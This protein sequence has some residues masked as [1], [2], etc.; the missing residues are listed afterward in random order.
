MTKKCG[1]KLCTERMEKLEEK[2]GYNRDQNQLVYVGDKIQH[3]EKIVEYTSLSTDQYII[4]EVTALSQAAQNAS[5][6]K[7]NDG[8]YIWVETTKA[9]HSFVSLHDNNEHTLYSYGRYD[10]RDGAFTGEGVLLRY[11]E[12]SAHDYMFTNLYKYQAKV[13]LITDAKIPNVQRFFDAIYNSSN[14]R[15]DK[16]NTPQRAKNYGRVVDTY[17]LTGNNCTTYVVDALKKAGS[18]VFNADWLGIVKYTEDFMIP[19]SL[20]R[21]LD[22]KSTSFDLEVVNITHQFK[23]MIKNIENTQPV[24]KQLSSE[25]ALGTAAKGV[26]YVGQGSGYSGGTFGGL[27]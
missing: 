5:Q 27:L 6:N 11:T 21:F 4:D 20:M 2:R 9:G 7:I 22:D 19:A 25:Q 12:Q 26:G 24:S 18:R 17:D 8:V 1:C 3:G 13:Y 23:G 15:P 16:E 10:D 14:E